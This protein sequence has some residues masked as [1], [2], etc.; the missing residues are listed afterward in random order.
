MIEGGDPL[1][2]TRKSSE[3]IDIA[4]KR[5]E[6]CIEVLESNGHQ[7]ALRISAPKT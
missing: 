7:V 1:V 2:L 6:C 3:R 5:N 4:D